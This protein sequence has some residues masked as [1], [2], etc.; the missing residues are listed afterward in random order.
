M[1]F[2]NTKVDRIKKKLN[3]FIETCKYYNII[4]I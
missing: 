4:H 2:M 3:E 1:N